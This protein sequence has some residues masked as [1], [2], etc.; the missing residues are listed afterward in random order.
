MRETMRPRTSASTARANSAIRRTPS[1]LRSPLSSHCW[2]VS[3][4]PGRWTSSTT[5]SMISLPTKSVAIG[6]S[7]RTS[8]STSDAAVSCGL[9]CHTIAMKGRRFLSAPTRSL[10]DLVLA[11]VAPPDGGG[12]AD[13]GACL[14]PPLYCRGIESDPMTRRG[15]QREGT[16]CGHYDTFACRSQARVQRQDFAGAQPMPVT[17]TSAPCRH[18]PHRAR[19]APRPGRQSADRRAA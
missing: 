2:S 15:R 8:R 6:R 7:A 3:G 5:S 12:S 4:F 9:V 19:P 17:A 13:P 18:T 1:V 11:T 14:P 10:K 16:S